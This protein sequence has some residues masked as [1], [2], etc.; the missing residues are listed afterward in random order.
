MSSCTNIDAIIKTHY[1]PT[2]YN[3]YLKELKT[4]PDE[5]SRKE[6]QLAWLQEAIYK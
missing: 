5:Q 3:S 6:T 1:T 2:Q 4:S